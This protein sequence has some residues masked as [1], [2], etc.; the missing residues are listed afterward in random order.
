MSWD[1]LQR[2]VLAELGHVLYRVPTAASAPVAGGVAAVVDAS[3]LARLA[4]AAGMTP[5]ALLAQPEIAAQSAHLR[6]DAVAKRALW[7]RLRAL[8]RA[9]SA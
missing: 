9:A 8:R 3:M 4:R 5:E 6:G 2:A 1:G 7:P